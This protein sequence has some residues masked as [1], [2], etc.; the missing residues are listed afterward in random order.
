MDDDEEAPTDIEDHAIT[1]AEGENPQTPTD[2]MEDAPGTPVAP[3]F[4]P[5]SPPTTNRTTRHG[6]KAADETTPMKPTRGSKRSP[7]DGWR[8]VKKPSAESHG[9]KRAGDSLAAD[10]PKRTRA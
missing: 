2:L 9:Q 10:P 3:K 4:A 7:F 1:Q 8:R 5:A 6:N